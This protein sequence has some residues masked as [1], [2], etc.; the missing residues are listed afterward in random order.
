LTIFIIS[1]FVARLL[2]CTSVKYG[3]VGLFS[4]ADIKLHFEFLKIEIDKIY[5]SSCFINQDYT[6]PIVLCINDVRL[7]ISKPIS[8]IVSVSNPN[9]F[10]STIDEDFLKKRF[11]RYSAI[12]QYVCSKVD[13]LNVV[14]L[15][16]V[17]L[18]DYLVHLAIEGIHLDTFRDRKSIQCEI[19]WKFLT[20]KALPRCS[21][22]G[23]SSLD[24]PQGASL[25]VH[26]DPSLYTLKVLQYRLIPSVLNLKRE[27]S[28]DCAFTGPNPDFA[29]FIPLKIDLEFRN[30][31]LGF[32]HITSSGK[33]RQLT[34]IVKS[35][36]F[37]SNR[38]E[39]YSDFSQNKTT[40]ELDLVDLQC[41]DSDNLAFSVAACRALYRKRF[42]D[43]SSLECYIVTL[44]GNLKIEALKLWAKVL[45]EHFKRPSENMNSSSVKQNLTFVSVELSSTDCTIVL[46]DEKVLIFSL[47]LL[48]FTRNN[49]NSSEIG[50]E[51]LCMSYNKPRKSNF[52]FEHGAKL[53]KWG[54]IVDLGQYILTLESDEGERRIWSQVEHLYIEWNLEL[55]KSLHS[56]LCDTEIFDKKASQEN[57]TKLNLDFRISIH[58]FL[59]VLPVKDATMEFK[60]SF[61]NE[62]FV[63]NSRD[64]EC[65]RKKFSHKKLINI[66]KWLKE[67]HALRKP[68]FYPG[69]PLP[70]DM[71]ICISTA[72]LEMCDDLFEVK[73]RDNYELLMDEY[74]EGERRMQILDQKIEDL[75]KGQPIQ[76]M[77]RISGYKVNEL[78][79]S[80]RE[81]NSAI[82][83]ERS[84]K[85]YVSNHRRTSLFSWTLEEFELK[86]L[87]DRSYHGDENFIKNIQLMN[88]ESESPWPQN[89][90]FNTAWCRYIGFDFKE[91]LM[92]MRDYPQPYWLMTN[93]HF[94]GRLAGAEI[95][96][97]DR[98]KRIV[99]VNVGNPFN[100]FSLHRNMQFL[101]FYYDLGANITSVKMTYGPCWEPCLAMINL[102][103]EKILRPSVDPSPPLPF[104]DK[105]RLLWHGRLSMMIDKYVAAMLAS[106]D[107]YD[108][109]EQME[110]AWSNFEFDWTNGVILVISDLDAY[111][112]T[113]SKY[114]DHCLLHLPSMKL[115][116]RMKWICNAENPNDHHS[117]SPCAPDKLPD[118]SVHKEHDSYRAF[119]S[120]HLNLSLSLDIKNID[121][122]LISEDQRPSV[123][124]YAN[125]FRWLDGL[126][127][128]ISAVN[129]PIK[130]GPMFQTPRQKK[131]QLSR[132]YRDIILSVSL[133][134]F[135]I[136]YWTS[137]TNDKGFR[138]F[139]RKIA[140]KSV[141]RLSLSLAKPLKCIVNNGTLGGSSGSN[142][143]HS[144]QVDN[145]SSS[146]IDILS[147]RLKTTFRTIT[148]VAEL[149]EA[150][151]Y[152]YKKLN[153]RH[154]VVASDLK[155]A[156]TNSNR[157]VVLSILDGLQKATVLRRNLSTDALKS[158]PVADDL[159]EKTKPRKC[160]PG[161]SQNSASNLDQLSATT[162][163]PPPVGQFEGDHAADMLQQLIN[164][165]ATKFMAYSE[166]TSE[167]PS[168]QLHGIVL[169]QMDDVLFT[170]WQIEVMNSQVML[171]GCETSGYVLCTAAKAQITQRLHSPVWRENQLLAKT[172]WIAM[173]NGM[174]YYATVINDNRGTVLTTPNKPAIDDVKWLSKELIQEKTCSNQNLDVVDSLLTQGQ[175]AGGVVGENSPSNNQEQLQRIISKCDCQL[176][177]CQFADNADLDELGD[178][179]RPLEVDDESQFWKRKEFV[180][181]FT[182]KHN[183]LNLQYATIL[184]IINNLILYVDPK[185]KES[186]EK[187]I[188][189]RFQLQLQSVD[190][191]RPNITMLQNEVREILSN[192]RFLERQTYLLN[193]KLA[194]G[195]GE[196]ENAESTQLQEIKE[197]IKEE[198]ERCKIDLLT[199]SDDLALMISCF[200]EKQVQRYRQAQLKVNEDQQQAQIA[201]RFE[202]CFEDALWRLTG[203][204]GQI[205][206]SDLR[207]RNFLY[208]KISRINDS[209]EHS[210]E[211]GFLKITTLLPNS[212]YK[213]VLQPQQRNNTL[214]NDRMSAVRIICRELAPVGGISVKEHFEINVV[215][216]VVQMSY[217]F[218]RTMMNYFFPDRN[219]D[220][221]DQQ[222]LD[223]VDDQQS[224][225]EEKSSVKKPKFVGNKNI[226]NK[227]RSKI[228]GKDAISD[229][230]D[231]MKKRAETNNMFLYIK[232]PEVPFI[233]SYKG[234]KEKNIEDVENFQLEIPLIEYHD[235]NWTWLDLALAIKQRC[236]RVLLQQFMKQKLLKSR[237]GAAFSGSE[238]KLDLM[239]LPEEEKARM[240][241]G[242]KLMVGSGT[243]EKSK[244]R[245]AHFLPK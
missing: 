214:P 164:E 177:F 147:R 225:S 26:V 162:C 121:D 238:Q 193:K 127:N 28:S 7:E 19:A 81:T 41:S 124:L 73:L 106:T 179:V 175:A 174:Q 100:S 185:N 15:L 54:K 27:I 203:D 145:R 140:L 156:W 241:L 245:L 178:D 213:D 137:S 3:H 183:M 219:I 217:A 173:L 102:C 86:S 104:W 63:L 29:N 135:F 118:Y 78:Y 9:C 92:Q 218:F 82:Y 84:K 97:N 107:P 212:P 184:D 68:S 5:L 50:I 120:Q 224:T 39:Y 88:P 168:Q 96:G 123:S 35:I 141:H 126:K 42:N 151:I 49:S 201:R 209:G 182:L 112:R 30:V 52:E 46:P 233:V 136:S 195:V 67:I 23:G 187:L 194:V 169:S 235:R 75:R 230:I 198:M 232:I 215:P 109:T 190:D 65:Y 57:S 160:F 101:K 94:F 22:P 24:M 243:P 113:A 131:A 226:K 149:T 242:T 58:D 70:A 20:C 37:S 62:V 208:T 98:S 66:I 143:S 18:P 114:D 144:R 13:N 79:D 69:Q 134:Q 192:Q 197:E 200:R 196:V 142:T 191:L 25:A 155:A 74:F 38:I 139:G 210:L 6:K 236:K 204:D 14:Y 56:A 1:W 157:D 72:R 44:I 199:K 110:F 167:I 36:L 221:E 60:S 138:L 207:I 8:T 83:V 180:D 4:V 80:L 95:E 99:T 122:E 128:T 158:I 93:G 51:A 85:M 105:M 31:N 216:M 229:D 119:R 231:K 133:P 161:Q 53:H 202:V 89:A 64:L 172:T 45:Q 150:E 166:E 132:H 117:V 227:K 40:F 154:K 171:K 228:D 129:R 205:G 153:P 170:K 34:S 211:L 59:F 244:G 77:P 90:C 163:S 48:D 33:T 71:M 148:M 12:L 239:N 115:N 11:R 91:W 125:T 55:V 10:T 2:K 223:M 16:N 237:I 222:N 146:S 87:A 32:V 240:L 234:E 159:G 21:L 165:A 206:L 43:E 47:E 76:E 189:Y 61:I 111:V 188:R 181:C 116:I 220:T 186:A 130:R 152:L 176:Y 108:T 103:F 17:A